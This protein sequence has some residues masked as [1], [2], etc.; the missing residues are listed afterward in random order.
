MKLRHTLLL[1]AAALLF[2]GCRTTEANYRAAY[3]K[4][5]ESSG[6]EMPLDQT[7]YGRNRTTDR[8]VVTA[9]G[10]TVAVR[11][12]IVRVTDDGGGIRESLHRY[13]VV[14]G[15][16]KQIFNAK[17]F[18][19][20]VADNGYPGAFVVESAEPFYYIVVQSFDDVREAQKALEAAKK[21]KKVRYLDGCPFILDAT[22]RAQNR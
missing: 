16:F 12:Q 5:V 6:D 3:E 14:A 2:A 22:A 7:I 9:A 19:N 15:Q 1:C 20:R 8:T 18:R 11:T 21:D 4:A 17:S 13:N 10:D